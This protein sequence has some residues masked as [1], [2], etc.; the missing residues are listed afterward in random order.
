MLL[1]EYLRAQVPAAPATADCTGI[2]VPAVG[3][4]VGWV[5]LLCLVHDRVREVLL[6]QDCLRHRNRQEERF[7][8]FVEGP[9]SQTAA[10]AAG[11]FRVE[12]RIPRVCHIVPDAL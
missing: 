4:Q 8:S 1:S 12:H 6:L 3:P 11:T 2:P 10:V 9:R 5:H 7:Q